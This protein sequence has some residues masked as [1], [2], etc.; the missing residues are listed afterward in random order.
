MIGGIHYDQSYAPLASYTSIRPLL[1]MSSVHGW[2]TQQ[3]DYIA[4]FTQSLVKMELY[5]KIPK[6]A[7]VKGK[8][9]DACV[10]KL[11]KN[12]FDQKNSERVWN[13]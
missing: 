11:Q 3:L 8:S 7:L 5:I 12:T 13:D 6:G 2:H 4:A 9:S 10:F 1:L